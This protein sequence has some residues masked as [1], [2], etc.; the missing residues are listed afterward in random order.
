M[1]SAWP[2]D[3]CL[4]RPP[5]LGCLRCWP[6]MACSK[7][8]C[9]RAGSRVIDVAN[10]QEFKEQLKKIAGEGPGSAAPCAPCP[11]WRPP[12]R[13][14]RASAPALSPLLRPVQTATAWASSTSPPSGAA[15]VG[16]AGPGAARGRPLRWRQRACMR[17]PPSYSAARLPS[18]G[19]RLTASLPWLQA[20]PWRPSTTSSARSTRG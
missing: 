15:H 6:C 12:G 4:A 14:L 11:L 8:P 19:D 18:S 9:C 1:D 16:G 13:P 2:P 20:R 17:Q 10:D 5:L 3:A 7:V